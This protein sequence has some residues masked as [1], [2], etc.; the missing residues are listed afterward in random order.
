MYNYKVIVKPSCIITCTFSKHT[1]PSVLATPT[2]P[3]FLAGLSSPECLLYPVI[4]IKIQYI[5]IEQPNDKQSAAGLDCAIPTSSLHLKYSTLS[6]IL[7]YIHFS[8]Y[9]SLLSQVSFTVRHG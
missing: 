6:C 5:L 1:S 2:N 3:V 9:I 4:E 7:H 8:A